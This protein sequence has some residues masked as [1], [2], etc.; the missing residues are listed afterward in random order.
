MTIVRN[1]SPLTLPNKGGKITLFGPGA[2]SV[3]EFEYPS[4]QEDVVI[5]TNH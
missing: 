3:D 1:G 5:E 4:S 2:V